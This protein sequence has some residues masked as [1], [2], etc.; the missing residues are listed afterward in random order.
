M[1]P[2]QNNQS[3]VTIA[4][5]YATSDNATRRLTS[6]AEHNAEGHRPQEE[7]RVS[8]GGGD[9]RHDQRWTNEVS[10]RCRKGS[11]SVENQRL[12]LTMQ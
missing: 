6:P 8:H 9:V 7:S 2:V 10:P 11:D 12:R 5:I 1:P 3:L 4:H